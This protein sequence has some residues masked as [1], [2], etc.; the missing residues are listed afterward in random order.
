MQ[1]LKMKSYSWS[2]E[3][4][5]SLAFLT[6]FSLAGLVQPAD[7][8]GI[9]TSQLANQKSFWKQFMQSYYGPYSPQYKCWIAGYQ[10]KK[11]CM[12]PH[13]LE[14]MSSSGQTFVFVVAGGSEIDSD[15]QLAQYHAA[16]G[17]LGLVILRDH[18]GV[19]Q[20]QSKNSLFEPSGSFGTSL[21]R[22]RYLST[23]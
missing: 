22:R 16:A 17:A 12:R 20:L 2:R 13:K 21:R 7:A 1:R 18:G 5:K 14:E 15:G 8:G 10:G 6:L 11:Y 9:A 23:R 4:P 19:L 3:A